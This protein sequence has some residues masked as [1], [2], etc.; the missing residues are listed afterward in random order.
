MEVE[1]SFEKS[2]VTITPSPPHSMSMTQHIWHIQTFTVTGILPQLYQI[3]MHLGKTSFIMG[4]YQL[5]ISY[6]AASLAEEHWEGK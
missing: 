2:E 1:V 6:Y 4:F 5:Q 3:Q